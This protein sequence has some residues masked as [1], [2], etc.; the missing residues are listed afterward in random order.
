MG[1]LKKAWGGVKKGAKA[2]GSTAQAWGEGLGSDVKA[3]GEGAYDWATGQQQKEG[4]KEA[5]GSYGALGAKGEATFDASQAGQLGEYDKAQGVYN[6]QADYYN[7]PG[8]LE[9]YYADNAERRGNLGFAMDEASRRNADAFA[10]RGIQ[11]STVSAE[12]ENRARQG[13]LGDYLK[14]EGALAAG[15]DVARRGHMTDQFGNQLDISRGRAGVRGQSA[16]DKWEAYSDAEKNRIRARLAEKGYNQQR[17]D[18]LIGAGVDL[19]MLLS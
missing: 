2:V 18:E 3:L 14:Q 7:Q 15:A 11:N 13:L 16:R 19:A 10:A 1:W 4:Y 17:L 5:Q 9:N 6:A 8:Y 12:Y